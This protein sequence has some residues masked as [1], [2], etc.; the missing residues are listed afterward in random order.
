M[1]MYNTAFRKKQN[2]ARQKA[3][4]TFL[5]A[6]K[7]LANSG[8]SNAIY[9]SL[10]R[11]HAIYVFLWCK[12]SEKKQYPNEIHTSSTMQ[13]IHRKIDHI[14]Y[15]NVSYVFISRVAFA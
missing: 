14:C 13:G 9:F 2:I 5:D 7:T 11:I 4:L 6:L 10:R 12:H 15:N 8:K 3:A 1:L